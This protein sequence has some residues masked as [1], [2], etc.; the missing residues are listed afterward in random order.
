MFHVERMLTSPRNGGI[1]LLISL[2]L[3]VNSCG[4]S[5]QSTIIPDYILVSNGKE[6]LG[7]KNLTAFIFENNLR[8]L[9]IEQYLSA[10]FKTDNYSENEF[11]VT[12]DKDKF[13]IIIYDYSEFEKYFNSSNY[14]V[15]NEEPDN[16]KSG[17]K[18]KFIA[19]SMI[20]SFNE[21]CLLNGS[22]YQNIAT[23]YL[24]NLKDEYYNQ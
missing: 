24:K 18:R 6:I 4:I 10:K 7:N 15:K 21:D 13:K 5:R 14:A 1:I 17:D 8:K 12:I 20:N 9:P 19:I 2:F 3:I 11:W 16:V 22:L 23:K